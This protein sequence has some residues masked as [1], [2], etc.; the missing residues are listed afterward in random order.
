MSFK[1]RPEIDGLRAIAVIAVVIYH[2]EFLLRGEVFL[3]GGFIGVDV[4]FVISGYLI[5]SI[6]LKELNEGRFSFW[7]FYERRAR[8]ILP[9]LFTVMLTSIPFAWF[10]MLPKAM[11]EYAGSVL[12]SLVFGSNIWFWKENSY[13]AEPS[14]LKPF[15]HTW[16]LSIEEQ[17]YLIFP[18]A[19]V[20]LWK[21]ARRFIPSI[22]MLL[23]VISLIF[24]HFESSTNIDAAFF[25]LP[26]RGWELLAGAILAKMELEKGRVSHPFLTSLMPV[27][28]MFMILISIVLFYDIM[29]HPSLI[30][31]LPILGTASLIWFC[32]KGE[33]IT[34]IL[35]SKP[36]LAVGLISYGLYIWHFPIFAFSRI[37]S[38][39]L[40]DYDKLGLI[41]FAL[42][43][44][45]IT[46]FI[47]EKPFRRKVSLP[48]FSVAAVGSLSILLGSLLSVL[49]FD[50]YPKRLPEILW[51]TSQGNLFLARKSADN[52]TVLWNLWKTGFL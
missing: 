24:S 18:L 44:S 32:K 15:L 13:T 20:L 45:T 51:K 23:F 6:I 14:A 2:A 3:K 26:S 46:Y 10:F 50:G 49:Y 11:K 12:S 4:F 47:V 5:T 36:F 48:V 31:L 8:R 22:F 30:T 37:K 43:L 39:H 9:I 42:V 25:L 7:H 21:Y 16:S 41:V 29:Q 34:A 35:S 19:L 27:L 28:G 17:Y 40:S 52:K 38:H 33:I 1:Y